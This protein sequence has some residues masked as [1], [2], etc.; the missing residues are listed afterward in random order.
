MNDGAQLKVAMVGAGAMGCLFGGLLAGA[1]HD[2]WLVD[3]WPEQVRALNR[4]GLR[5]SYRDQERRLQVRATT[6]A[7]AVGVADLVMI[8]CK[9]FSTPRAIADSRVLIGP[10]STVC[11]LQNGLGN[12]EAIEAAVPTHQVVY[13]VTGIGSVLREPGHI[14]VTEGA[15]MGTGRTWLGAHT[16]AGRRRAE[17]LAS[18][19]RAAGAEVQVREDIDSILWNKLAMAS[20]ISC[21]T[22]VTRLN[23]G[24]VL[25]SPPLVS[26]LCRLTEEVVAVANAKNLGLDLNAAIELNLNSYRA[27]PDHLPSMLQ[28]VLTRRR[29]EVDALAGVVVREGAAA[30]VPTPMNQVIHAL[31]RAIEDHYGTLMTDRTPVSLPQRYEDVSGAA[32]IAPSA[33]HRSW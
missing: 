5:M 31:V 32:Q 24:Q 13:G 27:S 25:E 2:V 18:L 16:A 26:I 6:D 30:G 12:V 9:A 7:S 1:G 17:S 8:W 23:V 20:A 14:E 15:W 19:L 11:T 33:P 22:A 3:L 4:H 21:V 28:D 29:T 10:G